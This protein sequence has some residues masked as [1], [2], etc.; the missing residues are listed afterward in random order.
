[1]GWRVKQHESDTKY[2]SF[3]EN[4]G[5]ATAG[6]TRLRGE[7]INPAGCCRGCHSMVKGRQLPTTH[8][9]PPSFRND[10]RL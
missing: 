9:M 8:T 3:F 1:M 10:F 6:L 4:A 2:Q 7:G 5:P